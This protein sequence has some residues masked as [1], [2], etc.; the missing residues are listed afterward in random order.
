MSGFSEKIS[1]GWRLSLSFLCLLLLGELLLAGIGS[2]SQM[3][4]VAAWAVTGVSVA[5]LCTFLFN[6]FFLRRICRL[7][8]LVAAVSALGRGDLTVRIS[9]AAPVQAVDDSGLTARTDRLAKDFAGNFTER[10]SL[11]P[12]TLVTVGKIRVPAL[13][14]GM[15]TLNLETTIVDLFTHSSGGVATI[16]AMR[17]DNLVRIAT[18]L[19]KSDGSRV[20]GTMLDSAGSVYQKLQK[21]ESYSGA[22]QLFG[23]AYMTRYDPVKSGH[24]Q[25]IGALFVGV[26][27]AHD[28]FSGDEILDLARGINTVTAEF[29]KFIAGLD[30]AAE[31]VANAA[32]QLAVN[33][34]RVAGSSRQQSDAV[35]TTSAA[36]EQVAVAIFNSC[37]R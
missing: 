19:K 31:S 14:S 25:I 13:R 1:V 24:G 34:E 15:V 36:V 32:T 9:W 37:T 5:L 17:G 30:K 7:G 26:E 21:G 28:S 29:G 16:F 12:E 33:T 23:K 35:A 2:L 3:T 18:S 8:E 20:V 27:L 6:R 10:F 4:S 22:A 11:H